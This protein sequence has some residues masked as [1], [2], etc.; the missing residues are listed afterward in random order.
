MTKS[1]NARQNVQD[2]CTQLQTAKGYL[3]DAL[4]SV[5]KD[6][7]RQKI[8]NTLNAVDSALQTANSTLTTY[9]E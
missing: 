3:N 6:E 7:N 2:V 5:E 1:K 4:T 8:Q 9:K